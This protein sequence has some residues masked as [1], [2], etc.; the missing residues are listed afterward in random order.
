MLLQLLHTAPLGRA[1]A[2]VGHWSYVNNFG[3]LNTNRVNGSDGRF[4]TGTGAFYKNFYLAYAQIKSGFGA[5]G[6]G[7]LRCV[8]SV[9]L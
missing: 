2:I 3:N 7:S 9:L 1:T 5:I 4:T 8:R 6:S